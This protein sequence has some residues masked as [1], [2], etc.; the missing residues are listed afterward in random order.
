[1]QWTLILDACKLISNDL[2]EQIF[3]KYGIRNEMDV[4]TNYAVFEQSDKNAAFKKSN[5]VSYMDS[6]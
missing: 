6:F 2:V 4:E 5:D 1:M 3:P